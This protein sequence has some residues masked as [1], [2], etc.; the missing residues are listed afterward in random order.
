MF[1][2]SKAKEFILKNTSVLST[3]EKDFQEALGL[4]LAQDI[5]ANTDWPP[6]SRS[7]MDGFAV[8][9]SD[10]RNSKS[11][12]PVAL[13]MIGES[14]AGHPF[15]AT[16]AA[17][18]AVRVSTGAVLPKGVDSVVMKECAKIVGEK[19][20]V[21][22]RVFKNDNVRLKRQDARKGDVLI[23]KGAQVTPGIIALLANLGQRKVKVFKMS[24]VGIITTGNELVGLK[25]NLKLG[26]I[27]SA[28]EY[29]LAAQIKQL[30]A[31]PFM[32]GNAKDDLVSTMAK[33]RQGFAFDVLLISGGV[34]V[35]DH[36][37]V[38]RALKKLKAKEI[39]WKV[40]VKPGKPLVFAKKGTCHI[41]G[42]PG[43]TAASMVSFLTFVRP[44][45]LKM[46]G[47]Q[48]AGP[49]TAEA[50]LGHDVYDKER[51]AK[52][53]RGIVFERKGERFVRLSANQISEN[54]IS[55]AKANCLF[56]VQP[57]VSF[58]KKGSKVKVE[59]T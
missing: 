16:V 50:I 15:L 33:I 25:S 35:G 53:M 54:V 5:V 47:I 46:S 59:Y 1:S 3:E 10:F 37:F 6:F 28:N 26:Q 51:R 12:R 34:S 44:C 17:G 43:N 7:T 52:I 45:L 4:I 27:R 2:L 11:K 42:L 19:V 55:M 23:R 58:I 18:E 32:L 41:F 9:S 13:K 31:K 22:E 30:G 14:R 39:F 29:G 21:F 48:D 57:G 38:R 40:A 20:F 24:R 49:K 56:I 36:D 8:R